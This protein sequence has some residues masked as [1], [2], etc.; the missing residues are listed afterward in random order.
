MEHGQFNKSEIDMLQ[1]IATEVE[2]F[3]YEMRKGISQNKYVFEVK[4]NQT[5]DD[6]ENMKQNV[7]VPLDL[8]GLW[9]MSSA[10]N[11]Q[12]DTLDICIKDDQWVKCV[13]KELITYEYVEV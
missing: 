11:L 3:H 5:Y 4:P 13:K 8:V 2:E 10:R 9:V 7:P 1:Y 12:Y 6:W